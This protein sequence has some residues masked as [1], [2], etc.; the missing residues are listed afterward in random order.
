MVAATLL[1]NISRP[2]QRNIASLLIYITPITYDYLNMYVQNCI[3]PYTQ[4]G[5]KP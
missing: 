3:D 2:F 1:I 5:I 4:L